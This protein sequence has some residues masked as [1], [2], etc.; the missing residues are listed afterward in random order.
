MSE[1]PEEQETNDIVPKG[2]IIERIKNKN[3]KDR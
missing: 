3:F 1:F 2:P